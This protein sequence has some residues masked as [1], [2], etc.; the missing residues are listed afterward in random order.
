LKLANLAKMA[1][2]SGVERSAIFAIV[3]SIGGEHSELAATGNAFFG[4]RDPL[5]LACRVESLLANALGGGVLAELQCRS[6][7]GSQGLT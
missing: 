5:G 4:D 1:N 6:R 2:I 3:P 7:A